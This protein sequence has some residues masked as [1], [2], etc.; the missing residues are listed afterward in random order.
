[1]RAFVPFCVP[2][3]FPVDRPL[4]EDLGRW[5]VAR[6]KP[7]HEK[8]V[9]ARLALEGVGYY[10][11]V[12]CCVRRRRDNGKPRKA[13][14]PL[15]PGYISFVGEENR[16][17]IRQTGGAL[18]FLYV[19]DQERFVREL[20]WIQRLLLESCKPAERPPHPLGA[21]MRVVRG[22]LRGVE[23][24]LERTGSGCRLWVGVEIF[25]RHVLVELPEDALAPLAEAA[26]LLGAA[27]GW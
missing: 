1:M 8:A 13:L 27:A 14:L 2:Q 9:A 19:N 16:G 4:D 24:I 7:R 20:A 25:Q 5:V 17:R 3:R 26:P 6:V 15:F 22:P 23:G 18:Q 21:R 10:L 12:T 11:P